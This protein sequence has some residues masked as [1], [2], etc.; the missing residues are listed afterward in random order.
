[1]PDVYI[2]WKSYSAQNRNNQKRA[3]D[4]DSQTECKEKLIRL[5][6]WLIV[7]NLKSMDQ[8]MCR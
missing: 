7:K 4:K 1:M 6:M 3:F 5:D 2:D 8:R